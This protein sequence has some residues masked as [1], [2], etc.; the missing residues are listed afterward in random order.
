MELAEL[1]KEIQASIEEIEDEQILLEIAQL[2]DKQED[3]AYEHT[4][5]FWDAINKARQSIAEG[6]GISNQEARQQI[7]NLFSRIK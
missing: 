5:E 1:K 6:K 3:T 2:L 7:R 4:N